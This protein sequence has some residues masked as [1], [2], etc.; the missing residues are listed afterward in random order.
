[1]IT[2]EDRRQRLRDLD[3]RML[4]DLDGRRLRDLDGR[5]PRD[6]DGRMPMPLTHLRGQLMLL[7]Q[8]GLRSLL[9]SPP[10]RGLYQYLLVRERLMILLPKLGH[11]H[12]VPSIWQRMILK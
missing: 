9:A 1:M 7:Q 12:L 11:L 4:R 10:Q 5:R 2:P 8:Q 6:L 3:S